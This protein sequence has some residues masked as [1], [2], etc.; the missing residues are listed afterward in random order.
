MMRLVAA[1]LS[2]QGISVPVPTSATA[3]VPLVAK[4]DV[5]SEVLAWFTGKEQGKSSVYP[6][7]GNI[8]RQICW[9]I[10]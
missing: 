1:G 3:D 6:C 5:L 9:R 4:R 10:E 7:P 8:Q 2:R